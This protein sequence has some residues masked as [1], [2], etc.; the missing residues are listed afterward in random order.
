MKL[1]LVFA[2]VACASARTL[3]VKRNATGNAT[4]NATVAAVGGN[5]CAPT[6]Q[7]CKASRMLPGTNAEPDWKCTPAL[8]GNQVLIDPTETEF[9]AVLCGPAKFHFSSMCHVHSDGRFDYD[10]QSFTV[11]VTYWI[12]GMACPAAG[13]KVKFP[14]GMKCFFVEC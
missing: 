14:H 3:V 2:L 8:A 5:A 4:G 12:D 6:T 1:S 13:T 11:D 10:E 7:V 9:G